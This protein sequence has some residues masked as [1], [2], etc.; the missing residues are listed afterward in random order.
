MS[1]SGR[2]I[3]LSAHRTSQYVPLTSPKPLIQP[4]VFQGMDKCLLMSWTYHRSEA[5]VG[6]IDTFLQHLLPPSL[7]R[8]THWSKEG[9]LES[10]DPSK[11]Y[12]ALSTY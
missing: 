10:L 11:P 2:V 9:Q 1:Q 12:Q 6:R 4:C 5:Y 8:L 7:S 3:S